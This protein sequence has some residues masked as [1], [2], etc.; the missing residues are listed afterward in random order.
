MSR[1]AMAAYAVEPG[2]Q[3]T[4]DASGIHATQ[5]EERVLDY[6]ACLLNVARQVWRV[7]H[8]SIPVTLQHILYPGG[9]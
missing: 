2:G 7:A 3:M 8:Q 6:V 1:G 5:L 4:V 9:S